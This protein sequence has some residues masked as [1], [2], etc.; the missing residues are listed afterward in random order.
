MF[1]IGEG[2]RIIG[3]AARVRLRGFQQY[4]GDAWQICER[5]VKNCWNGQYFQTSAGHFSG[6]WTRDFGWCVDALLALGYRKEVLQTL[7][8]ALE[9]FAE[10]GKVTTTITPDGKPFDFARFAPDS[11]AFLAHA[12]RAAKA[13]KLVAEYRGFLTAEAARYQRIV[14]DAQGLVLPKRFSSMRDGIYRTSSAYDTAMVGMLSEA[15]TGLG[16][17]HKL[18]GKRVFRDIL[19]KQ[20]WVGSYFLDD[21]S[22]KLHVAGDAQVFPF[23][24]G[25]VQD[26]KRIAQA[27]AALQHAGLDTP[28]PLKY[29]LHPQNSDQFEQ[30][31]FAPNYEGNTIWA[32]MGL[33]YVRLLQKIDPKRAKRHVETYKNL[34]EKYRTFL[35]VYE[36]DGSSA[37]QSLFY[38]ADEAM[39][40]AANLRVLL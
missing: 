39:L 23:W 31:F 18:P 20:Y 22:G 13:R 5:I 33:L 27:F 24:T 6:F 28:F 16:V 10:A 11:F 19:L 14:L 2:L 7:A 15:L 36:P 29:V 9:R 25:V 4:E 32:H 17:P 38:A 37:Y 3:R 26:K 12:L 1:P 8:Y 40:W 34:V 21:L 30:R 35:E